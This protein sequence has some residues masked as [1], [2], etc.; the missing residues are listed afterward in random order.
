MKTLFSCNIM[1]LLMFLLLSACGSDSGDDDET[2]CV[3]GALNSEGECICPYQHELVDGEC[4]YVGSSGSG[5]YDIPGNGD[6]DLVD[7]D[8]ANGDDDTEDTDNTE[9]IPLREADCPFEAIQ[10][11]PLDN[12]MTTVLNECWCI[13]KYEAVVIEPDEQAT[14]SCDGVIKGAAGDDYGEDFPDDVSLSDDTA[15]PMEACQISSEIP[16]SYITK[17]QAA[18]ACAN[19]GKVLCPLEIHD[20]ACWP[21]TSTSA[22]YCPDGVSEREPTFPYGCDFSSYSQ[23]CVNAATASSKQETSEGACF[24]VGSIYNLSGNLAEWVADSEA[25]VGGSYEHSLSVQLSC[26]HENTVDDGHEDYDDTLGHPNVGFRCCE[27]FAPK[28]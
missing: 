6:D 11:C 5:D 1:F 27:Q 14:E 17:A 18:A 3:G 12:K 16:S 28:E 10:N 20:M 8:S 19:V 22:S 24:G 9:E 4:R 7:D 25:P 15:T 13:D 21:G 2:A 23:N 26:G